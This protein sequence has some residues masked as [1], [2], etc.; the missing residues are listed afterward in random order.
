MNKPA[1]Y[2]IRRFE[3]MTSA[4]FGCT[5]GALTALPFGLIGGWFLRLV[6]G[7]ARHLMEGWQQAPLDL[8]VTQTSLDVVTLLKLN[9]WLAR[10]RFLDEAW[11]LV[12]CGVTLTA[13][14]LLGSIG[15]LLGILGAWVYNIVAAFSGGLSIDVERL[16]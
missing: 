13:M 12:I 16:E 3:A 11:W 1:H 6:L 9:E 14:V 8:G 15:G 10:V 4:K 2:R 5:G 7:A